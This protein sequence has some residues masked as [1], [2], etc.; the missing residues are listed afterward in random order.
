MKRMVRIDAPVETVWNTLSQDLST[1]HLMRDAGDPDLREGNKLTWYDLEATGDV[2]R[3]KGR[4]TVFAPPR[5]LAYV[6][7][8]PETG[9]P[10]VPENYTV[11]DITITPDE[12]GRALVTVVHG[13]FAGHPRGTRLA[14]QSGD[15]WVDALVRLKER[16][17]RHAAA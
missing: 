1:L 6:V 12:D 10:D 3:L 4:V 11:V 7:Y 2:P 5:H 8:L 17:E 9:L 13:D 14:K 16:V 15:R